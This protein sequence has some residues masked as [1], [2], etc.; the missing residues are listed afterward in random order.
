MSGW[1]RS[2][3]AAGR[4]PGG[5][6]VRSLL[7]ATAVLACLVLPSA[8]VA[9]AASAGPAARASVSGCPTRPAVLTCVNLSR[10]RL[11]VRRGRRVIFGPVPIRTGRA[12]L[13]TPDGWFTVYYRNK[14]QW[15]TPF[16]VPMPFSQFFNGGDA[17]HGVFG[18]ISQGP[19]SHGCVNLLYEDAA[20]L[21]KI[22]GVGSRVYIWGSK[23][24]VR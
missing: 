1:S 11:W 10:Q 5:P 18:S 3:A 6:L 24:P 2:I 16:N 12:G 7:C 13:G 4:V 9:H 22:I 19:G 23:P 14:Y 20:R 8:T 17:L 21:W 15:S